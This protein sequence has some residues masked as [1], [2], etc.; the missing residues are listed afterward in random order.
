MAAE[1]ARLDR[2]LGAQALL[3][4]LIAGGV[5]ATLLHPAFRQVQRLHRRLAAR[6]ER[7]QQ[8]TEELSLAARASALGAISAHLM[9]GLRNPLAS[10]S[11]YVASSGRRSEDD[12]D[13]QDALTATRRMQALVNETLEVLSSTK[14]GDSYEVTVQESASQAVQRVQPLARQHGVQIE[15]ATSS[16]ESLQSRTA[17]LAALILANLLENAVQATP[18]GKTVR[19]EAEDIDGGVRFTVT[20]E[21]PG[22]P[23][24]LRRQLF[25]PCTST[26]EGG[27]GLG[28]A[29][30]KQLADYLGACLTLQDPP[31]GGCRFELVVPDTAGRTPVTGSNAGAVAHQ[32]ED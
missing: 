11:E 4:F 15:M 17:N 7:L 6:N 12:E 18:R 16:A 29:I 5:L 3:A 14:G 21:G 25:L 31:G 23:D 22:F 13:W 10:L 20:D 9:H 30:S 28:L 27:S 1:Y 24:H 19:F 8:A 26:R 32:G 2:L